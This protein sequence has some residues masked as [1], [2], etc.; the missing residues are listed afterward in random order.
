[1]VKTVMLMSGLRLLM[2]ADQ[3]LLRGPIVAHAPNAAGLG[4]IAVAL[5]QSAN[6]LVEMARANQKH[7]IK[8]GQR[9]S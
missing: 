1:M 2:A 3:R 7:L 6:P 9:G 5:G 8:H 4:L